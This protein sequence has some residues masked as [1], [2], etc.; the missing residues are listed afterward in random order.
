MASADSGGRFI[1]GFLPRSADI[2]GRPS[3]LLNTISV[4]LAHG[5]P[6]G[7]LMLFARVQLLPRLADQGSVARLVLEQAFGRMAPLCQP[8]A[9]VYRGQVRFGVRHRVPGERGPLRT[10]ITPS[11]IARYTTGSSI[12]AKLFYRLQIAPLWSALSLNAG[13]HQRRALRR[14]RCSRAT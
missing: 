11:L 3:F 2:G 4:D 6:T 1:N 14:R 12:G 13:R 8:G 9:V 5:Q 10:G 7:T